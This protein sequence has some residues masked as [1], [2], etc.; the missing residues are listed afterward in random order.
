M[1]LYIA[2]Q[3]MSIV[4]HTR[5]IIW[6]EAPTEWHTPRRRIG[7]GNRSVMQRIALTLRRISTYSV[8]LAGLWLFFVDL[9]VAN[10]FTARQG[11][12]HGSF[13][14]PKTGRSRFTSPAAR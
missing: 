12:R 11:S 3:C 9:R 6:S 2:V 7:I 8:S 14:Y 1:A 5:K 13:G 4:N 10:S